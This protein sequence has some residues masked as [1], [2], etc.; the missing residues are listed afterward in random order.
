MTLDNLAAEIP[1]SADPWRHVAQYCDEWE[2]SLPWVVRLLD[3]LYNVQLPKHKHTESSQKKSQNTIQPKKENKQMKKTVLTDN[4]AQIVND[5]LESGDYTNMQIA[6]AVDNAVSP[7]AISARRTK[8]KKERAA[9]AAAAPVTEETEVIT[10]TAPATEEAAETEETAETEE[11]VEAKEA[12][13]EAPV[14]S[15]LVDAYIKFLEHAECFGTIKMMSI[16]ITFES[17]DYMVLRHEG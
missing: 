8:M 10:E 14:K 6:A 1:Y 12:P 2:L 4:Q 5:M 9:A 7:K 11:P 15:G 17:G 13:D 16:N 3:A